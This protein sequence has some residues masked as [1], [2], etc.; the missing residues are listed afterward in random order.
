[1]DICDLG[2][3]GYR[4]ADWLRTHHHIDAHLFDHR[5]ISAQLTHA[6]DERTTARLLTAL[7]ELADHADR[8]ADLRDAPQV[9][10]PTPA[11]LHPRPG[12]RPLPGRG[13]ARLALSLLLSLGPGP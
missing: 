7:R 5:R 2:T 10:V 4:A 3:T 6:D 1:M 8:A 9:A 12:P 13:P 11:G